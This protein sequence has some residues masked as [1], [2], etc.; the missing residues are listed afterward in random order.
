M[1]LS[2]VTPH[3]WLSSVQDVRYHWNHPLLT[4]RLHKF[5]FN[6]P[7]TQN[8]ICNC[9]CKL[10]QVFVLTAENKLLYIYTHT[11]KLISSSFIP[12]QTQQLIWDL[13]Q[14]K[15]TRSTR[16][17]FYSNVAVSCFILG[18]PRKIHQWQTNLSTR[19]SN[20]GVF[21]RSQFQFFEHFTS[22]YMC[23]SKQLTL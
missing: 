23:I 3:A 10:G 18:L 5:I 14:N 6:V 16:T 8:H 13:R 4:V 7:F 12:S 17:Q 21:S 2:F 9:F 20:F 15:S 11:H 1:D 19:K 22:S